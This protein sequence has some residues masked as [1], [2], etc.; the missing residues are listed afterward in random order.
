MISKIPTR[1]EIPESD[2][3]WRFEAHRALSGSLW[4]WNGALLLGSARAEQTSVRQTFRWIIFVL[5]IGGA[6]VGISWLATG[7]ITI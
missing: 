6:S 5:A 1:S 2:T 7:Y 3:W 4:A